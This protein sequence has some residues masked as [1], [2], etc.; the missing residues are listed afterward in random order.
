MENLTKDYLTD[1]CHM[2]NYSL[3]K[4]ECKV[5]DDY[6]FICPSCG[7]KQVVYKPN[8]DVY[9]CFSCNKQFN[10]KDVSICECGKIMLNSD[11]LI[12]PSCFAEKL[13]HLD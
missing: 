5:L 2:S 6:I 4:D 1:F 7:E 9:Y 13:E 8:E 3:Y 11:S 10:P 12:C